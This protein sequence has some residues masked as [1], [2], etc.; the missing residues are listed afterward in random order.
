MSLCSWVWSPGAQPLLL[1]PWPEFKNRNWWFSEFGG[2]WMPAGTPHPESCFQRRGEVWSPGCAVV[3]VTLTQQVSSVLQGTKSR[4]V[5]TWVTG[6]SLMQFHD[7][8]TGHLSP[9]CP[10]DLAP[11]SAFTGQSRNCREETLRPGQ[12]GLSPVRSPR[13]TVSL[14]RPALYLRPP[15]FSSF[16]ARVTLEALRGGLPKRSASRVPMELRTHALRSAGEIQLLPTHT[17]W[18][19]DHHAES[20]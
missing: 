7:G 2:H 8:G 14:T 11:G 12:H 1:A 4:P 9:R 3:P 5:G 20:C 6:Q 17:C 18:W 19:Q 15:L 13:R 16:P 10:C